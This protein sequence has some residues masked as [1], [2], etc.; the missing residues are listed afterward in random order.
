MPEITVA[1][2]RNALTRKH[3]IRDAEHRPRILTIAESKPPS[4]APQCKFV[5]CV[6]FAISFFRI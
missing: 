1:E 4:R 6:R 2:N 3:Q 5:R